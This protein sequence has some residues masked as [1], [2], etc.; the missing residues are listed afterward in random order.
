M[1]FEPS[2]IV[3]KDPPDGPAF[4]H[5]AVALCGLL[6][7]GSDV[8]IACGDDALGGCLFGATPDAPAWPIPSITS[9]NQ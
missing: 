3:R 7:P 6:P 8:A 9:Q 4:M 1:L 2:A 5:T